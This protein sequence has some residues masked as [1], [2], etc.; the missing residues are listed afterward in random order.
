MPMDRTGFREALEQEGVAWIEEPTLQH[1]YTG[2]AAIRDRLHVPIQMGE[3][4][5]G[6]EDMSKAVAAHACDLCMPDLMKIGGVTGW[7]RASALAEQNSLPMS[8]HIFQ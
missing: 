5:F 7:L 3:N 4:W 6:P 1:D 8:S 2:H